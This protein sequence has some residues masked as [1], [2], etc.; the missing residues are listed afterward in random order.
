M[1]KFAHLSDLHVTAGDF[2]TLGYDALER[3]EAALAHILRTFPEIAFLAITGD[4]A[5]WG[6]AGA[7]HRLRPLLEAFPRPVRVMVGNHDNRANFFATFGDRE[8][9]A[10]PYAQ[11]VIDDH[12]HRML[13]L[14]SQT[15]NTHGGAFGPG[16]LAWIERQ[17]ACSPLPVLI[18]M[19]HHP[20][21]SGAPSFDAK[22]LADAGEFAALL[23]R[24][25]G[26]VRHIF[27]GHCHATLSGQVEGVSFSG[28]RSVGIQAG[29]DL[30]S[31]R[32]CRWYGAPHYAV[33]VVSQSS[34]VT[35]HVEFLHQGPVF[36]RDRQNFAEFIRHCA[37]RGVT[38]PTSPPAI[39]EKV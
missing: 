38:V 33:A 5:N 36:Y 21:P 31:D 35:H 10:T 26:R 2:D 37:D 16:R 13:F 28:I 24:H 4:L 18:F 6:E 14:D 29:T 7:Y 30:K 39:P 15:E 32:A 11:Y 22:G 25:R 23:A 8:A 1:F 17:I 20:C 9:F 19:H 27:H 3:T 34:I 12:G